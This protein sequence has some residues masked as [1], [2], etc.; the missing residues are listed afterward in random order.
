MQH[1]VIL[2]FDGECVLCNKTVQWILLNESSPVIYFCSLQSDY[3]KNLIPAEMKNIDSVIVH[4]DGKFYTHFDAFIQIIPYLKVKW[5]WLI[6]IKILPSFLRKR[7]YNFIARNRKK[8]FGSTTECWIMQSKWKE[9][10]M[11]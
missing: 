7:I 1:K 6:I 8:W 4:K 3:A 10:M 2:F 9:R 11:G 5:K